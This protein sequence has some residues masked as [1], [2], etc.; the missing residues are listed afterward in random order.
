MVGKNV[1]RIAE[2][3]SHRFRKNVIE[4]LIPCLDFF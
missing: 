3:I 4:K 2:K 1:H